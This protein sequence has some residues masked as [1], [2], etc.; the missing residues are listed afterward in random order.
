MFGRRRLNRI[1]TCVVLWV[2]CS[3]SIAGDVNVK[4]AA[5]DLISQM[6]AES[7][8]ERDGLSAELVSLGPAGIKE[9]C[10][11]VVPPGTGDDTQ[12][13]FAL[14]GLAIYVTRPGAEAERKMY[15]TAI[16]EGFGA[17]SNKEVKAFLIRQLQ[18]AGK[19]EAVAP[20]SRFLTDKRLCEPATQVLLTIRTPEAADALAQALLSAEGANQVTII[21]ALGEL[22]C[23]A[24][25]DELIRYATGDNVCT[26]RAAL[27]A[28]ANIGESSAEKVLAKAAQ[29]TSPYDRAKNTSFYLLYA[30]RLTE[31]GKKK[32]AAKICRNLIKTRTAVGQENVQCA[33]LSML[34]SAIGKQALGDLLRAMDSSSD[35]IHAAALELAG[36]IPGKAATKEWIKKMKKVSPQA[37]AKILTMLGR[38]GDKSALPT[39]LKALSADD[40]T[41]RMAAIIAVTRLGGNEAISPLL[42]LMQKTDQ[43]DEIN[44][45]K[46]ALMS[47]STEQVVSAIAQALP[48]TS[49]QSKVM[50]MEILAARGAKTHLETVFVQTKD[51]DAS[52][53]LAAIKALSNL[54]GKKD[55][56]RLIELMLNSQSTTECSVAQ[57]AIVAVAEQI[58][59]SAKRTEQLMAMLDNTT[60]DKK[61]MLLQ[62][63]AR[64]GGKK[65]L[66]KVVAETKSDDP[67]IKDAAIRALADWKD[68]S[69]VN[70]LLNIVQTTSEL[71]YKVLA[72]RGMVRLIRASDLPAE[73]KVIIYRYVMSWLERVEE[74]K[75]VLAAAAN[76]KDIETLKFA[77]D[78]LNDE[79]L[80]TEAALAVVK[81]ACPQSDKD[82]GLY[83]HDVAMV[84]K[85]ALRFIDDQKLREQ[86]EKHFSTMPAP[87]PTG[88]TALFNGRDLTGWKRHEGL[89]GHNVAGKWIVEDGVIVGIQDPPGSGGFLTTFRKFRDFELSLETKID[90]P[91]DSGV[92]LRVGPHGKS[93]QVTLDYR[94][95]GQ[96]G[97]IYCPWTQGFVHSCP[98]GIKYFKKNQWNNIRITCQ[99][100]PARI[101]VWVN[102]VLTTDFQHTQETTAGIPEE[103][104]ICLQIHP[105]GKGRDK[106]RARFR[107]IF[108]REIPCAG[109]A[110]SLSEEEKAQGF[111]LL[112]NGQNLSGWTGDTQGYAA[113][114]GK[115][116]IYPE[117]G[118]GNL[119][120]EKEYSNFILRFEFKLTP[121]ANNGLAIRAPLWGIASYD[122]M[123]LQILDNTADKWKKLKPYQYHGSIYGVAPAKRGCLKPTG[124]WNFQEVI[125]NGRQITVNL[126]GTTILDVDLE[127]VGTPET[128]DGVKHP[129]LKRDKGHIGF[130]GHGD[131]LEFRNL[132]IKE[133]N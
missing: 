98:E 4:T 63:L 14:H 104:T 66:S 73:R 91:F 13:R 60:G 103:G 32:K 113:E 37:Q 26:R 97:G 110:Q 44:T 129:G 62:T 127:K 115:I 132:R 23:K 25:A 123:E 61:V 64:I 117:L 39:L 112:F 17:A 24:V 105:G 89:P 51:N 70:A 67:L 2:I 35:Q 90:W 88:F 124:Q 54:A 86:V 106:T 108:I 118:G 40:K 27:Y 85:K 43:A 3:V 69:A 126:N 78:Y 81:I 6:P 20:L 96:I 122:G 125:A 111:V 34:V 83:G 76:I 107:D 72:L 133:L 30:R 5:A 121:A 68:D 41:V 119:Y 1:M 45:A 82:K 8:I 57:R 58:P 21:K 11:M 18:L 92:F 42:A 99:G 87:P 84:L 53:R 95:D 130:L 116:V 49:A 94:P 65:A 101:R 29:V 36:A 120:T 10:R 75:F 55:M 79:T 80:K 47:L 52:V 128:I 93:H 114:N 19:Q 56:P 77:S 16:I 9:I 50:F 15:A 46:D 74:K 109:Y 102:G 33:A 28:I 31:M 22:R 100:Q 131:Y 12:A 48:K 59:E 71:K 7:I 38:R